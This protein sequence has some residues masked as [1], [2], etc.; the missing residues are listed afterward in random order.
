MTKKIKNIRK[1]YTVCQ[2]VGLKESILDHPATM[3]CILHY[4]PFTCAHQIKNLRPW[5]WIPINLRSP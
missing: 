3:C 5:H 4:I 2:A 1:K